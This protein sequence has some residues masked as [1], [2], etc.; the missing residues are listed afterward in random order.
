MHLK[1]L[2]RHELLNVI[3]IGFAVFGV[4]IFDSVSKSASRSAPS[5]RVEN[6]TAPPKQEKKADLPVRLKIPAIDVNATIEYVGLTP[7][8]A[9]DIPQKQENVAWYKLGNLPGEIGNAVIAGH[10]GTWKNG[11]GSVFD[12]LHKLRKGD[13]ISVENSKGETSTFVVRESRRY[14]PKADASEVFISTDQKAHLNLITCEGEWNK[15][16]KSFSQR[17]VVFTDKE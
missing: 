9:M 14:T 10:Y 12:N 7:D 11:K 17:L 6:V 3:L 13:K 1:S 2:S 8:G 5:P 4:L 15:V 16:S